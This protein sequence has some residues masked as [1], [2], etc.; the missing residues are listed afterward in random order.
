MDETRP[1]L[2]CSAKQGGFS[3]VELMVALL[4]GLVII[5]GAGQ[6]FLTGFQNFRKVEELADKQ[7]ALTFAADVLLREI[8]RGDYDS[9][10]YTISPSVNG[11]SYSIVY[12]GEPVVD[13]LYDDSDIVDESSWPYVITLKL[14]SNNEKGYDEFVFHAMNRTEAVA[15]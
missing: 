4:I 1:A 10:K 2:T 14:K 3:L 7:A 11:D 12:E 9:D 8:R 13:G 6:F 5:L 15:N